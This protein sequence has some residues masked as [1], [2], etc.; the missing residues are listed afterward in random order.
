VLLTTVN[1]MG[2]GPGIHGKE[3][4]TRSKIFEYICSFPDGVE[5]QSITD[6]TRGTLDIRKRPDEQLTKLEKAHLIVNIASPPAPGKTKTGKPNVWKIA[7]A[8]DIVLRYMFE[9]FSHDPNRLI[10]IYNSQGIKKSIF[11]IVNSNIAAYRAGAELFST[12]NPEGFAE[13]TITFPYSLD[14]QFEGMAALDEAM[15]VS[16]SLLRWTLTHEEPPEYFITKWHF[17]TDFMVTSLSLD[18]PDAFPITHYLSFLMIDMARYPGQLK[19]ILEYLERPDVISF[20][21]R[22]YPRGNVA[23]AKLNTF[24][25]FIPGQLG[26]ERYPEN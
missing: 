23:L 6:Y 14:V 1:I 9:T 5:T 12:D 4:D 20:V 8:P 15:Y 16:P 18:Y 21:E 7:D 3:G 24:G 13:M 26:L 17:I 2:K 22:G 10:R 11:Y 19:H 25:E